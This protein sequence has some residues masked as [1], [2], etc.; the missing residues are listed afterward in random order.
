MLEHPSKS[1]RE[2]SSGHVDGQCHREPVIV[3]ICDVSCLVQYYLLYFHDDTK[4][5]VQWL[6][7][8]SFAGK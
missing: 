7:S 1:G 8:S 2:G 5:N 3:S 4:N 6:F